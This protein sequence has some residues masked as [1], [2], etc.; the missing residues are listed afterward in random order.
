VSKAKGVI[1]RVKSEVI[2]NSPIDVGL[3]QPK[4]DGP[5]TVRPRPTQT[6]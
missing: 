1:D 4:D 6:P 2:G 3:D 5:L